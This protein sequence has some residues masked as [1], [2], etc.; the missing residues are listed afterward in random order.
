[1]Q[2]R[3]C[4]SKH[5]RY[6]SRRLG[7]GGARARLAQCRLHEF[8]AADN[9]NPFNSP[10]SWILGYHEASLK[11][12]PHDPNRAMSTA[13]G[14]HVPARAVLF[15]CVLEPSRFFNHD[16]SAKAV[17]SSNRSL[18][19]RLDSTA[20][21]WDVPRDRVVP[22]RRQWETWAMTSAAHN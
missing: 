4:V 6:G 14:I 15:H 22:V 13:K 1:M 7:Q 2:N 12:S 3:G 8:Y 9:V 18:K 19:K 17:C 21:R 16:A 20:L 10:G 5:P 11:T